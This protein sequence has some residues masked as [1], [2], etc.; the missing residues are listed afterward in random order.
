MFPCSVFIK[1]TTI[2]KMYVGLFFDST[3]HLSCPYDSLTFSP[4]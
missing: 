2:F 3:Y 1:R 4:I